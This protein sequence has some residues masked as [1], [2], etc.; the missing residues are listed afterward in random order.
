MVA[1]SSITVG[2]P[3]RVTA[4]FKVGSVLTS[5]TAVTVTVKDPAGALTTPAA[6]NDSVGVYHV[7]V[8]PA[9]KGRHVVRFVGSGACV[10]AAEHQ[11]N[12][13]SEVV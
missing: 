8:T 6:T 11:F 5:P 9:S 3:W 12:A 7:D 2:Q 13:E 4:T 10:A 1:I